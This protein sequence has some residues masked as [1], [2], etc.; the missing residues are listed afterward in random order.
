MAMASGKTC[1]DC[2]FWRGICEKGR[3]NRT[4]WDLACEVFEP[5]IK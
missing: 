4:A 3:V 5:K 2:L 1:G